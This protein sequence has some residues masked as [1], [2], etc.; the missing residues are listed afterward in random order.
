MRLFR[1][2]SR[3]PLRQGFIS[4]AHFRFELKL[5]ISNSKTSSLFGGG[6]SSDGGEYL[7]RLFCING[8]VLIYRTK[9]K[10]MNHLP[11]ELS[12]S[13]IVPVYNGGERFRRCLESLKEA[14]PPPAEIIVVADGDTDGSWQLAQALGIQVLKFPSCG[15]PARARNFGS[16]R[17]QGEILF[18]I[19][20]DVT[21]P[22][23]AMSQV[24]IAFER[25]PCLAAIFGSYDD[26]PGEANFLSQYRNLL[27]HYVHQTGR[28]E[29]STFWGACG[30]IRRDVFLAMGGFDEQYGRP[31]KVISGIEDIELGYRLKTAGYRI[32]L[33]KTLQVKHLK[34]WNLFS[35]VR[36]DFFIRA[37]PWTKLILRDRR[38]IN[39]LNTDISGR[40]SVILVFLLLFSLLFSF[41]QPVALSAT[42]LI[43]LTLL[44][45]NIPLYRFFLRKRGI[46][47]TLQ[48]L[49][50]HWLYFF[51]SGVAFVIGTVL[52]FAN[53]DGLPKKRLT[54]LISGEPPSAEPPMERR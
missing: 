22:R 38:F 44:V 53:N 43:A 2:P 50:Y 37:L 49:P 6:V 52:H 26:E 15:G 14:L 32:R 31:S 9:A 33:C 27:H 39:D 42:G 17:A 20:A 40:A 47:F 29:A 11:T 19:D 18:F 7:P 16:R 34:R 3:I 45:L 30:A 54:P 13:V 41:S 24:K 28:E 35:M 8:Q 36:T 23:D 48:S 21:I 25:E 4:P 1:V 12:V 51:Y 10:Q 5:A 46:R